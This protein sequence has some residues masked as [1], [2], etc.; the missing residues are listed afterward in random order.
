[1]ATKAFYRAKKGH[2]RP[3]NNIYERA[4]RALDSGVP[5]GRGHAWQLPAEPGDVRRRFPDWRNH[6]WTK[7]IASALRASPPAAWGVTRDRKHLP[8]L[9]VPEE[10]YLQKFIKRHPEVAWKVPYDPFSDKDWAPTGFAKRW[11]ELIEKK[12]LSEEDAYQTVVKE[13]G[14]GGEWFGVWETLEH[15]RVKSVIKAQLA[16]NS[17]L[18]RNEGFSLIK[19]YRDARF[20]D[21]KAGI[22]KSLYGLKRRGASK[23]EKFFES[24]LNGTKEINYFKDIT[25]LGALLKLRAAEFKR[26]DEAQTKKTS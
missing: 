26:T 12:K 11:R 13:G 17:H 16:A 2:L 10:A 9:Q 25:E 22:Q 3:M 20:A 18:S 19:F 21:V 1:M 4:V 23:T 24:E 8:T 6:V 5:L 15:D 14:G 7:S